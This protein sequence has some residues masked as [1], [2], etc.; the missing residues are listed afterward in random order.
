[1]KAVPNPLS[2]VSNSAFGLLQNFASDSRTDVECIA[3]VILEEWVR[4]HLPVRTNRLPPPEID[5][6]L[7]RS[8]HVSRRKP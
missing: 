4:A 1:M 5:H 3:A 2:R 7:A 6:V 8:K